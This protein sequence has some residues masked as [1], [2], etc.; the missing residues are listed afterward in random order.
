MTIAVPIQVVSAV[1]AALQE[2]ADSR[3]REICADRFGDETAFASICD[4]YE[5][6]ASYQD[7]ADERDLNLLSWWVL[8]AGP[9]NPR[10]I[11]A[12]EFELLVMT[13]VEERSVPLVM[14]RWIP[15]YASPGALGRRFPCLPLASVG[16]A[17]VRQAYLGL[18]EHVAFLHGA[19]APPTEICRT[20]VPW[21]VVAIAD[22]LEP[23][24][25]A[26][27][28]MT[29][30]LDRLRNRLL[31]ENLRGTEAGWLRRLTPEV[32]HRRNGLSHLNRPED[33]G[34][35]PFVRCVDEV[36]DQDTVMELAAAMSLAVWPEIMTSVENQ[37]APALWRSLQDT[38]SW[39]G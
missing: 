13:K 1:Y 7:H 3:V 18:V 36:W 9:S 28:A 17:T 5:R 15:A 23:E 22:G 39:L 32:V 10:A 19:A 12:E 30:R 26:G 20:S 34:D 11:S 25:A 8:T 31:S 37:N 33:T 35:W 16:D 24:R 2:I 27:E 21:R 6:A 14:P 38:W 4:L 29:S